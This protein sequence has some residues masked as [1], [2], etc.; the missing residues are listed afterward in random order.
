MLDGCV[1]GSHPQASRRWSRMGNNGA[2]VRPD[3][4]YE[5]AARRATVSGRHTSGLT[6]PTRAQSARL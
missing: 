1:L 5:E 3:F 4:A 2:E 6:I